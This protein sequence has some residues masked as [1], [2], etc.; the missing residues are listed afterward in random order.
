[1]AN[2]VEHFDREERDLAFVILAVIEEAITTNS[3][4]GDAFDFLNFNDRTR[5]GFHP[6][7]AE[8]VMTRRDVEVPY[9]HLGIQREDRFV[10]R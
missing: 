1:L 6:V 5:A 8:K 4:S 7:V 2:L 3:S 10:G 9:R